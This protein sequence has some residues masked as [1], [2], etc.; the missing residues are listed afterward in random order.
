MKYSPDH[1]PDVGKMVKKNKLMQN[2]NDF[3]IP[4]EYDRVME[5]DKWKKQIPCLKFNSEWNVQIIPPFSGAVIRFYLYKD[6][7]LKASVY[8][9]CY[10]R[11]GV[12]GFPYWEVYNFY[13][14]PERFEMNDTERLIEYLND[15]MK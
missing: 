13:D 8:L 3:Q 9:D 6:N 1:L 4:F 5:S 15:I 7:E 12:M 2:I 10:D 11:L 14:E